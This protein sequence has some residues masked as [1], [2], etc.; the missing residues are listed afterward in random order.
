MT[1]KAFVIFLFIF[2]TYTTQIAYSQ[3]DNYLGQEIVNTI[4]TAAPF[5]LIAPDARAGAMGDIGV[6]TTPDVASV[7]WN[8][9]K[10]A[11]VEKDLGLSV[12]YTPWLRQLVGDI[13]LAYLAG[14]KRIDKKQTVGASLRYFSLGNIVFTDETGSE[15]GSHNP[16]EFAIDVS[17]S[18]LLAKRLSGGVAL[19]YIY[20]NLTGGQFVGSAQ[21]HAGQAAA[22]DLS[23]YY[24]HPM[25]ISGKK[26]MM[27]FGVNASNIGT[28]ISYT[29]DATQNFLPINLRFGTSM[30]MDIDDYNSLAFSVDFNK[31]LVP[32]PPIYKQGSPDTILFGRDPNVSVA[33]GIFGSFSDAPGVEDASGNRSVMKEE[34][35]EVNFAVGAE[36]WYSKQFAIRAGYFHEHET[37]GN[38]KF[39]S[40]GLG[41]KLNVFGLDFAYLIP[42]QGRQHPL[43]STLRFSLT[44][45]FDGFKQQSETPTE[46]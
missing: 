12:S 37:K 45:D 24:Q 3:N 21:S 33:S 14:Y 6:A 2:S 1:R 34:L 18:F 19:R 10:Y 27:A 22:A 44:F 31:L 36:Y 30:K 39:F 8:P 4:T 46:L 38:R 17:Y 26:T 7:H 35:R 32:T 9:A 29:D 40:A 5:L 43:S 20:S 41:L 42:T 13:S 28:K 15:Y 11:F 23:V 25:E 16:S